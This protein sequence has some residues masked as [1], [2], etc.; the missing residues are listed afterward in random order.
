MPLCAALRPIGD[1]D[2]S[3]EKGQRIKP[4]CLKPRR[5]RPVQ[6]HPQRFR[7]ANAGVAR[8]IDRVG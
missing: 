5:L 2:E 8:P 3:A 7:V 4:K 1:V 6:A